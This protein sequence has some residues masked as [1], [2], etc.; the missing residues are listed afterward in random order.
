[1]PKDPPA[2][3]VLHIDLRGPAYDVELV[4][5][6][7]H[8]PVAGVVV[9]APK[10]VTDGPGPVV[11]AL[12][13]AHGVAHLT[14]L[15]SASTEIFVY[16][17]GVG[18]QED[19]PLL[20]D[21]GWGACEFEPVRPAANTAVRVTI[22]LPKLEDQHFSSLPEMK[23]TGVVRSG[24]QPLGDCWVNGIALVTQ[25]DG[26]LLLH[27]PGSN[28]HAKVGSS[29]FELRMPLTARARLSVWDSAAGKRLDP[30]EWEPTPGLAEQQRDIDFP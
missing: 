5:A 6:A 13:D 1:M 3:L 17:R 30:I 25:A 27:P 21:H 10:S 7:T 19:D 9:G 8:A 15:A 2:D 16:L 20:W 11:S 18:N 22:E 12:T 4:D 26:L 28:T 14:G 29:G 23:L 24:G